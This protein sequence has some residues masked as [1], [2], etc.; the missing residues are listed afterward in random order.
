MR[1]SHVLA[2]V[3][4]VCPAIAASRAAA[5]VVTSAHG[6]VLELGPAAIEAD[7]RRDEARVKVRYEVRNRGDMPDEAAIDLA[8][9]VGAAVTGL[10]YQPRRGAGWLDARIV[11][12][13]DANAQWESYAT[14]PFAAMRGPALVEMKDDGARLRLLFVPARDHVVV[15]Y[16]LTA[17]VCHAVGRWIAPAPALASE[18][19]TRVVVRG[20]RGAGQLVSGDDPDDDVGGEPISIDGTEVADL[21]SNTE[22]AGAWDGANVVTVA[23]PG[24]A[25]ASGVD[26][27]MVMVPA[28]PRRVVEVVVDTAAQL[29]PAPRDAHV[30]FVIDASISMGVDGVSAQLAMMKAYL[31]RAPGAKF[32]LVVY[33][34]EA[35]RVLGRWRDGADVAHLLAEAGDGVFAVGNGS[36]LDLGLAHAAALLARAPGARRVVAFTDDRV[37]ETLD[38]DVVRAALAG[39]PGDAVVHVVGV[40]ATRGET[41][42]LERDFAHWL[43]PVAATWGG[44]ATWA[45]LGAAAEDARKRA[46]VFEELVRP[47]RIEGVVFEEGNGAREELGV[48]DEG[49]SVRMMKVAE[50][51]A[52]TMRGFIWGRVWEPEMVTSEPAW[53]RVAALAIGD[54]ALLAEADVEQDALRSLATIGHAVSAETSLW[55]DDPRWTPGGLP[56]EVLL[57]DHVNLDSVTGGFA[58]CSTRCRSGMR[59]RT[60]AL[61]T[62]ERPD[63][64]ALLSGGVAACAA[65]SGMTTWNVRLEIENT[66]REVV[67]VRLVSGTASADA[68][69]AAFAR[70]VVETGWRLA[71]PEEYASWTASFDVNV[72]GDSSRR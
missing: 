33:R 37:R 25:R 39:L 67:D 53:R 21:C 64:A 70:C 29:A 22:P 72:V 1:A 59:G 11:P 50:S 51:S 4:V 6:T 15:E 26:A 10:R 68:D 52:F 61:S 46:D 32:E 5:D 16:T 27:R 24:S 8:V 28:G 9:P 38:E 43:A 63:L 17:P 20:P 36:N 23:A 55:A 62:R 2:F 13:G 71:L 30:V 45:T 60:A 65:R 41:S 66:G 18:A 3:A 56:P 14:A 47:R 42:A 19:R 34:R 31:A 12:A 7:V 35:Q 40:N 48:I 57:G 44:V 54:A 58:T 49:T 69:D